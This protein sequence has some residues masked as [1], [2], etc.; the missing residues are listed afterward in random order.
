MPE[1][2]NEGGG[3][4]GLQTGKQV[5]QWVFVADE[6]CAQGGSILAVHLQAQP[7]AVD[8]LDD[9]KDSNCVIT[10]M[11][12]YLIR[13]ALCM[14]LEQQNGHQD[15]MLTEFNLISTP[16]VLVLQHSSAINRCCLCYCL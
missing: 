1:S 10:L 7:E 8:F 4:F 15:G 6:C 14:G 11:C 9:A 13:F 5:S 16:V 12:G 2:D 3:F